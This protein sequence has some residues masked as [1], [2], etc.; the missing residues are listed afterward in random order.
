MS[1]LTNDDQTGLGPALQHA[2]LSN[3]FARNRGAAKH[4]ISLSTFRYVAVAIDALLILAASLIGGAGYQLAVNSSFGNVSALIG[5]GFIG[6]LLYVLIA[7]SI[8]F[9]S[10]SSLLARASDLR[11]VVAVWSIVGLLLSLLAFLFKVGADFSRGSIICFSLLALVLLLLWRVNAT[12]I[13]ASA[14]ASGK[15]RGRRVVLLGQADELLALEGSKLLRSYGFS[16]VGRVQLDDHQ[17]PN[18]MITD[19]DEQLIDA[20]MT[21][22]RDYDAE[23]IVLALPWRETAR[24]DFIRSRLRSSPLPVQLLPDSSIRLLL[25]NPANTLKHSLTVEMQ[26]GPLLRI[27]QFLKRSLDIFGATLALIVL[28]PLMALTALAIKLDS[29][30]PVIFRQRRIGFNSKQFSIFKFRTMSV[31]EDGPVIQQAQRHDARVT[32]VG[33]LLRRSSIDEL[34]QLFNVLAGTMSCVGPRPHAVAHDHQYGDLLSEYALRH[35]VKPGITGWAQVNGYRGQ[36]L[37]VEQM[38]MRVEYDLWYINNWSL[39]LD[40]KIA[41]LTCLEVMRHRNAF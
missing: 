2:N 11:R 33:A 4:G 25:Q 13:V 30:G 1:L 10:L 24:L 19:F 18:Q 41:I 12:W 7:H 17:A 22:A 3:T 35:H 40:L 31:M 14:S 15:M 27:E 37:Q 38:K 5:A 29:P 32:R 36:I 39:L 23:E 20:A 8:G 16:E 21:M 9:Y 28:S 26:R 34:P 6:A